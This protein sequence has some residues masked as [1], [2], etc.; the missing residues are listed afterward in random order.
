MIDE[1]TLILQL[2]A[3]A[4]QEVA[5]RTL[6]SEYKERVYWHIRKMVY[7]HQDA[8]DVLQTRLS[9]FLEAFII[10][11]QKVNYSLG[12]IELQP[13]KPLLLLIRKRNFSKL[14]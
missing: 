8:D 5:F 2:K 14:T 12:F 7:D 1:K 11:K 9:K 3:K 13:T 4:T 10:L 6:I